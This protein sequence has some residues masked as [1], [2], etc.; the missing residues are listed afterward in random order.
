M[1][2]VLALRLAAPPR[3]GE[4][5]L[6]LVLA[7]HATAIIT[8]QLAMPPAQPARALQ[9]QAPRITDFLRLGEI[10]LS[11]REQAVVRLVTAGLRN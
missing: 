4:A 1:V 2:G 10:L 3:I 5:Q 9:V 7:H 8:G 11:P 6:A